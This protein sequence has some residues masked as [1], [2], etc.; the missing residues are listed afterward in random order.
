MYI[1][2]VAV[3]NTLNR[4]DER[5]QCLVYEG[6]LINDDVCLK[7]VDLILRWQP[8]N[9]Y[10]SHVLLPNRDKATKDQPWT[11]TYA[12]GCMQ[13][14]RAVWEGIGQEGTPPAHAEAGGY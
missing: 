8:W 12:S 6:M 10:I 4:V 3:D 1:Y 14:R 5:F 9:I 2:D 7:E 11:S 13:T